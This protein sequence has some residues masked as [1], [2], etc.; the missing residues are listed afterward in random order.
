[1]RCGIVARK[2]G[3]ARWFSESG[4]H[5]PVT[6]LRIEDLE[7][8]KKYQNPQNLSAFNPETKNLKTLF[9][10]ETYSDKIVR[11]EENSAVEIPSNFSGDLDQ[12]EE[13]VK[14]MMEKSQSN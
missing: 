1:M 5:V 3:M 6:V 4:E 13:M 2:L 14:S 11:A 10:K 12:L 9:N 7:V 8:A